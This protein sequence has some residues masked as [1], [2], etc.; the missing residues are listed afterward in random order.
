MPLQPLR[1]LSLGCG[2]VGSPGSPRNQPQCGSWHLAS[3]GFE[4]V[5]KHMGS[6]PLAVL[7][8]HGPGLR[9]TVTMWSRRV[10][11]IHTGQEPGGQGKRSQSGQ[12]GL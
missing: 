6:G 10:N 12:S 4:F 2:R 5:R 7:A 11:R 3:A 9:L 1:C 8:D